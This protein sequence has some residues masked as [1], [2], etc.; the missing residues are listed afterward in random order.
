MLKLEEL[1]VDTYVRGLVPGSVVKVVHTRAAG[2]D[3]MDVIFER[4]DGSVQKRTVFR[5]DGPTLA[6]DGQVRTFAFD[7]APT[8]F[9]LAAEATRIK[10]SAKTSKVI[11]GRAYSPCTLRIFGHALIFD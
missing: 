7:A 5:A 4:L 11:L 8:A 2:D 3:A 10:P 1:T 6:L 9:R